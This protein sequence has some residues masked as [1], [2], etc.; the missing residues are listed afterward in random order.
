M[1]AVTGA[2]GQLGRLVIS[3]LLDKVP[4]AS[5]VA[6]VRS[7]EKAADLAGK[8]VI[9]R[10][11]DYANPD[12]LKA[13]FEGVDTVLLISSSEVG[14]RAPQHAAV[15]AAAKEAGVKTVAYTSI[16]K[17][18][19]SPLML[20]EEHRVT[21]TDLKASGL[22]WVILRNGWYS[23]NFA[24]VVPVAVQHGA[25]IGSSGE[26]RVSAASRA[27]FAE[28][29]AIV[30]SDPAAH[31]GKTYEL[32]GDTGF[33]KAELAAEIAAQ[34]GKPVIYADMPEADYA[35][36]LE[37]AGIPGPFALVLANSDTGQSRGALED[38]SQ[39]LSGLIGRPT[40][41]MRNMVSAA[42]AG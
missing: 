5:V 14:Q 32:A 29:A 40:Q 17:A 4:A 19:S 6:A 42:L 12:T 21:E 24:G 27:D 8:G 1:I 18:D 2:T 28:A 23:E 3:A 39:V 7:P 16:L 11:A 25:V 35:A 37:Q 15:I 20:A 41:P 34:S 36:A 22:D 9:V 30:L 13:A 31:A 38:D 26:G 33:T 10:A